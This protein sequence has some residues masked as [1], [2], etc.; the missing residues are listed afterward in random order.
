MSQ[1]YIFDLKDLSRL[2]T[3]GTPTAVFIA[4]SIIEHVIKFIADFIENT[5]FDI[6]P[7][8]MYVRDVLL[9]IVKQ[10][11]S[12]NKC[13]NE[14]LVLNSC[15]PDDVKI[16]LNSTFSKSETQIKK[17]SDISFKSA[18]NAIRTGLHIKRKCLRNSSSQ[19]EMIPPKI[20][21]N[22][23]KIFEWNFDLFQ[24]DHQSDK[25]PLKFIAYEIFKDHGF[26]Q[27][28]DIPLDKFETM[29]K[30]LEYGY[31]SNRN[32]YHNNL[33]ACDVLL[34]MNYLVVEMKLSK[35][36][37]DIEIFASLIA[38]LVHDFDHTGT[39]NNFHVKSRTALSV[40]YNDKSVLENHHVSGF[41][42]MMDQYK[43]DIFAGMKKSEFR[44]FRSLLIEL[45]LSTDMSLHLDHL[46]YIKSILTLDNKDLYRENKRI[47]MFLLH[48][49]DI[50]HPTKAWNL[51][52]NWSMRC[53]E[54]FFLQGDKES[55]L[56]LDVSPLCKRNETNVPL[57]QIAFIEHVVEPS[58]ILL[59]NL[60]SKLTSPYIYF[61]RSHKWQQKYCDPNKSSHLLK[62]PWN[63]L[64]FLNKI[65]WNTRLVANYG[66]I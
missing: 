48:C 61:L 8:L 43:C 50:S 46:K 65:M 66:L 21:K 45:V 7:H 55:D 2:P 4:S 58:F 64:L 20:R 62:R 29:L 39:T 22:M 10:N 1:R 27:R 57:S 16:W 63:G 19:L 52:Y 40:L 17:R 5:A 18:I 11:E 3:P 26:L 23:S 12:T 47:L 41:F 6:T 28:F 33:H 42:R 14:W 37:S 44:Q 30:H 13:E 24:F 36:M 59:E 53:M 15:L 32:S 25:T 51:H 38:A 60:A 56:K 54:E 49:S 31:Q 35:F 9:W 34:T